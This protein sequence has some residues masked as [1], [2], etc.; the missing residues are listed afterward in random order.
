MP[1]EVQVQNLKK[2]DCPDLVLKVK[3]SKPKYVNMEKR[4]NTFVGWPS[5]HSQTPLILAKS[6]FY[7]LGA[8]D[9]VACFACGVGLKCWQPTDDP[10]LEHALWSPQCP[11]L[12]LVKGNKFMQQVKPSEK[13]AKRKEIMNPN[14]PVIS[15]ERFE[16]RKPKNQSYNLEPNETLDQRLLCIICLS[17]ERS[18]L[19]L[20]C[21]H[22]VTCT[23]CAQAFN[24]CPVC[25]ANITAFLRVFLP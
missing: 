1:T 21:K 2:K 18:C 20:P 15:K 5:C 24:L 16:I 23:Q 6:G 8:W 19:F 17:N 13:K 10:W 22:L 7:F 25:K 12:R 4:L 14:V 9:K 11:F 3:L